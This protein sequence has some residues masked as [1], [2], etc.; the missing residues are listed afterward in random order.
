MKKLLLSLAILGVV[1]FVPAFAGAAEFNTAPGTTFET[2]SC[3]GQTCSVE[4]PLKVTSICKL[5]KEGYRGAVSVLTPVA[6]LFIIWSGFRFVFAQG[7]TTK[8]S[9]AKRNLYWTLVG[10]AIFLGGWIIAEIIAATI[11]AI[12]GAKILIC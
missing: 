11:N 2:A 5:L 3:N 12:G 9:D 8:L 1:G 6:V 7:N 10:V 4:N